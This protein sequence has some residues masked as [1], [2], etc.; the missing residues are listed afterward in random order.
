MRGDI[1]HGWRVKYRSRFILIRDG[2]CE[3]EQDLDGGPRHHGMRT[4]DAL[5]QIFEI[6]IC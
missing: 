1:T 3:G 2:F 5:V 6:T 4:L